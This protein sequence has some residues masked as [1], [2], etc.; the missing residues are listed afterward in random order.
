MVTVQF[1]KFN[2]HYKQLELVFSEVT[3]KAFE[4]GQRFPIDVKEKQVSC[5]FQIFESG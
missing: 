2:C 4:P 5:D 3:G 1:E